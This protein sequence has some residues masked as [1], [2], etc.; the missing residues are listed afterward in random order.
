MIGVTVEGDKVVL[1]LPGRRRDV[2]L[3]CGEAERLVLEVGSRVPT[4]ESAPPSVYRGEVWDVRVESYDG[5]VALRFIPPS[6]G[7]PDRV[8]LP[9]A[10]A[11]KLCEI[12]TFK[13]QQAAYKMRFVFGGFPNRRRV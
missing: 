11:R 1:L 7:F 3:S 9:P 2:L 6:P 8:P 13:R 10:A 12:V 5:Y 4:A